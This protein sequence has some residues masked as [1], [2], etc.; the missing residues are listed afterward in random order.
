[1]ALLGVVLWRV[2]FSTPRLREDV[3]GG[4]ALRSG[5]HCRLFLSSVALTSR[6][7]SYYQ[8][9]RSGSFSKTIDRNLCAYCRLF[10][11]CKGKKQAELAL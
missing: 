11:V 5:L 2:A 3:D 1:M 9:R 7:D 4:S 6:C 8:Q 10:D